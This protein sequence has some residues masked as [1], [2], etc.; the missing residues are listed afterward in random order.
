MEDGFTVS[1]IDLNT[2]R[3][4]VKEALVALQTS[5]PTTTGAHT[6]LVDIE[7]TKKVRDTYNANEVNYKVTFGTPADNTEVKINNKNRVMLTQ[8][9]NS[10]L[11]A[12]NAN[13]YK[14]I[15]LGAMKYN[16]E[17][18]ISSN[19]LYYRGGECQ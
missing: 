11:L 6:I 13:C 19:Y 4:K 5:D 2:V 7:H 3:T 12:E 14:L 16:D 17:W 1:D 15:A 8:T 9:Y 10:S 18:T